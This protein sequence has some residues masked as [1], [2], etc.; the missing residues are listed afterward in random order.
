MVHSF[1]PAIAMMALF[2]LLLGLAYPLAV[3]GIAH[4][5]FP[6]Q[7]SGSLVRDAGGRVVG[8]A[9]IGQAFAGE[10]YLHPRPS[11]A[12]DGY[13]AAVSSGSNMGPLNPDLAARVAESAQAIRADDGAGGIPADAVTT[14]ASGL[15]PD[16]SPAYA[17]L[18]AAR[19]ARARGV[20]V[21]QVQTIIDGQT[22]GALLGFV[23]QPRVNVLLTNRALDAR[24]GA[25]G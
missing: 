22:Q 19:I 6:R 14:S 18:Q 16:V 5:V 10:T 11:A 1:R 9:L 15:D 17:R 21:Q 24:F 23:G 20:P 3:T 2:T 7:A 25:E 13:D 12:G 8:S 4:S